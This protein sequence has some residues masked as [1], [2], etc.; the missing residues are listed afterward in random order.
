MKIDDSSALMHFTYYM[1]DWSKLSQEPSSTSCM[2]CGE[3]MMSVEPII[4]KKG[5][6][7]EGLVCHK[8]KT[9]LWAR[10]KAP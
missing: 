3:K 7:F 1:M 4:D 2:S 9:V 5:V 8:C 6:V 10:S